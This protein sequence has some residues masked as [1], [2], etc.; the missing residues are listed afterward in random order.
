MVF[1][2]NGM[3]EIKWDEM[4]LSHEIEPINHNLKWSDS[5]TDDKSF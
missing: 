2:M 5:L 1:Q 4:N 3:N